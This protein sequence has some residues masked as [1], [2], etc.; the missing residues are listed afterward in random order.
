MIAEKKSEEKKIKMSAI[1][2]LSS[3]DSHLP[4]SP[5]RRPDW[6]IGDLPTPPQFNLK[7][8]LKI[9]GPGAITLSVSIGLGEWVLG[10]TVV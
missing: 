5:G 4:K 1:N 10:P 7:N 2:P 8:V 3:E 9:I 6:N